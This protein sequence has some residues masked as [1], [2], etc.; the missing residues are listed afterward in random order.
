MEDDEKGLTKSQKIQ[1]AIMA[2]VMAVFISL[3]IICILYFR[4]DSDMLT[5]SLGVVSSVLTLVTLVF[6]VLV[7]RSKSSVSEE[8]RKRYGDKKQ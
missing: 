5:I 2:V 8:Y 4:D 6:A 1:F 7:V 3:L